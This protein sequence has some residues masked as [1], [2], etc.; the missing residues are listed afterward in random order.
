[1]LSC[2]CTLWNLAYDFRSLWNLGWTVLSN[3]LSTVFLLLLFYCLYFE[4]PKWAMLS[5]PG[6]LCTCYLLSLDLL[7]YLTFLAL[8][9]DAMS[10]RS[11]SLTP[12][13]PKA[14][15]PSPR[16]AWVAVYHTCPL[17]CMYCTVGCRS[18]MKTESLSVL[19]II[20]RIYYI[21]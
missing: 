2:I 9:I 17:P 13:Q 10:S 12:L 8:S 6:G 1:M 4:F 16:T 3:V 14:P 21:S 11:A 5:V 18:F 19:L 20:L 7:S 15:P